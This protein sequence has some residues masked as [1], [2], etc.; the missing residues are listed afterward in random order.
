MGTICRI[1]AYCMRCMATPSRRLDSP[2]MTGARWLLVLKAAWPLGAIILVAALL[3]LP[4]LADQSYWYDEA[5]TREVVARGLGYTFSRLPETEL[6]PP[7]YYVLLWLWARVFGLQEAGLRSFSA[8]CGIVTIPVM[9]AAGRRI[10]S[11]RVGLIA[12]LLPPQ[13]RS[14]SGTRRKRATTRCSRCLSA[15]SLL[16]LVRLLEAP[17]KQRIGLWAAT[18]ALMACTHYFSFFVIVPEALVFLGALRAAGALTPS[19][20]ASGL[21]PTAVVGILVFPLLARQRQTDA[22]F[23]EQSASLGGRVANLII[24]N[25]VGY[26]GPAIAFCGVLLVVLGLVLGLHAAV[27]Y[28]GERVRRSAARVPAQVWALAV[29][30]SLLLAAAG[31]DYFSTRNLLPAWPA[32]ML[33][34]A[35]GFGAGRRA[36]IGVLC[37]ATSALLGIACVS[38]VVSHPRFQRG[39]WRGAADALGPAMQPR[40]IVSYDVAEVALQPYT[41]GVGRFPSAG[42]RIREVAVIALAGVWVGPEQ[43]RLRVAR[44]LP[45]FEVVERARTSSY[46]IVRYRSRVP[47]IARPETLRGLYPG[48]RTANVLLQRPPGRQAF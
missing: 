32:F 18:C 45:G 16:A 23:I 4:T 24:E 41:G 34:V 31:N 39:D 46:V 36:R 47:R 2:R 17:T 15:V 3:R 13:I 42:T 43:R 12:A 40:A 38:T 1:R 37:A 8:V 30:T 7:L 9:W 19:R 5:D 35:I 14:W 33:V 25:V 21:G 11:E 10:V 22:S 44:R 29:A 27:S 6:N 28:S 20:V 48:L 26:A